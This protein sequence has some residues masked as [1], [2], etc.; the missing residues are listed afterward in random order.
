MLPSGTCHLFPCFPQWPC[1]SPSSVVHASDQAPNSH[2]AVRVPK[3]ELARPIL[4]IH[5][6]G[7]GS[8][9]LLAA[10]PCPLQG[11]ATDLYRSAHP[12]SVPYLCLL[13]PYLGLLARCLDVTSEDAFNAEEPDSP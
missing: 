1:F 2:C 6:L 13:G 12:P 10:R 3:Q 4:G 9:P 5:A 8:E 11:Q 7:R